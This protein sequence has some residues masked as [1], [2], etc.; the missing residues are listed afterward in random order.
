MSVYKEELQPADGCDIVQLI[1]LHWRI[2][3]LLL[4][5]KCQLPNWAEHWNAN[6]EQTRKKSLKFADRRFFSSGRWE[7][8]RHPTQMWRSK[9]SETK[10]TFFP[11]SSDTTRQRAQ[12]SHKRPNFF[13][14]KGF[15]GRKY[16]VQTLV[17]ACACYANAEA[18]V[19]TT[20]NR[21]SNFWLA[22]SVVFS[23]T[24]NPADWNFPTRRRIKAF[25]RFTEWRISIKRL[26]KE[27]NVTWWWHGRA[28]PLFP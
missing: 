5:P 11:T 15:S 13:N 27:G 3:T 4:C 14:L 20:T 28:F 26:C 2:S 17:W 16:F 24:C 1:G 12:V 23:V 18:V 25:R 9:I 22:F 19:I 8:T 10:I 6:F 7:R 21:F